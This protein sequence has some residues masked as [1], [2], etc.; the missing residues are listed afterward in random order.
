MALVSG[1]WV[2]FTSDG[3]LRKITDKGV[4]EQRNMGEGM[5]IGEKA[6]GVIVQK[7]GNDS[8][9]IIFPDTNVFGW[10]YTYELYEQVGRT[11]HVLKLVPQR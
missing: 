7:M 8:F 1:T 10:C 4:Q 9:T 3:R 6:E 5:I 2:K 11:P